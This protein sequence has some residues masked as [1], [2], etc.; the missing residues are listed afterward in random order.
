MKT[1]TNNEVIAFI[2]GWTDKLWGPPEKVNASSIHEISKVSD[3]K[4]LTDREGSTKS[5]L[6]KINA[7]PKIYGIQAHYLILTDGRI[8]RG[9]PIDE[10][11]NPDTSISFD[12]TG[13]QVTI[14]ANTE[15]PVNDEQLASLKKL[16]SK[17]YT[18]IAGINVYGDYELEPSRL[19]PAIDMDTLRDV[20]GKVNSIEDPEAGTN[21]PSRKELVFTKPA[22]IAEGSKTKSVEPFSF[23]KI[24]RDI[25]NIDLATGEEL[26]ADAQ[27]DL[28]N[29]LK[30]LDDLKKGKLGIDE[31]IAKAINDPK[32]SAAK[33]QGDA[34]IG[35]LTGGVDGNKISVDTIAKKLDTSNLSKLF[36]R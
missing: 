1:G 22:V 26:P 25:A 30:A 23:S 6:A 31:G 19:G 9:R 18:T 34:I 36:K 4:N 10:V 16:L 13:V 20:Y 8:Q 27:A 2:V 5:A 24:Q 35:K 14:V 32:N 3:L 33:L 17:A 28:D 7:T 29:G 11:R 21:G 15:N 12:L